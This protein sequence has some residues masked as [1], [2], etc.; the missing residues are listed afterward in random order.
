MSRRY[1]AGMARAAAGTGKREPERP[2]MSPISDVLAIDHFTCAKGSSVERAFLEAV[3]L[4]LGFDGSRR[5][6]RSKDLLLAAIIEETTGVGPESVELDGGTVTNEALRAILDG[7]VANGLARVSLTN[8]PSAVR[9]AAARFEDD[10]DPAV[11]DPLDG[12]KDR[13][14]GVRGFRR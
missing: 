7:I 11:F 6:F 4:G 14:S 9:V 1:S 13:L 2:L 12:M 3:A 10:G 8:G 5:Q